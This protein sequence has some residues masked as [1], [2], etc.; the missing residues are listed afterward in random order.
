MP[1]IRLFY[2]TEPAARR[3]AAQ[4]PLLGSANLS[5]LYFPG[6]GVAFSL[7]FHFALF[8][9][10]VFR[11][12]PHPDSLLFKPHPPERF[13]VVFIE[14]KSLMY[15]PMLGGGS[16][17]GQEGG[18]RGG[19][20][21]SGGSEG[22][23]KG[24]KAAPA[25]R[26]PGLVYPGPQPIISDPPN[27][28]NT[29]QTLLQPGIENPP[30]LKP[31][32]ALPNFVQLADAGPAPKPEPPAPPVAEPDPPAPPEP[33][34][35]QAAVAQQEIPPPPPVP[36]LEPVVPTVEVPKMVLPSVA[37]DILRPEAKEPEPVAPPRRPRKPAEP[38]KVVPTHNTIGKTKEIP[39]LET[40]PL[41]T[42]G[43]DP[44]N[45]LALSPMPATRDQ[46]VQIPSGEA[47]ARFA[48]SPDPS[49]GDPNGEPGDVNPTKA[50][51]PV[52][53]AA[54]GLDGSSAT[55]RGNG[56]GG[57][58]ADSRGVGPGAGTGTGPGNST[59]PGSGPGGGTGTGRGTGSGAGV[60]PGSGTGLGTGKG[61]GLGPGTGSGAGSVAGTGSGTATGSGAGTGAGGGTGAGSGPGR[62]PFSGITVVGGVGP[63][64]S[65]A[66][67]SG[68][69]IRPAPRPLQAG[70][71]G[72]TVVSTE[73]S[74]GGL[75]FSGVF[76]HEQIYTVYLDM[77]RNEVEQAPSWTL[78]FAVIEGTGVPAAASD[79]SGGGVQGLVLPFPMTKEQPPLPAEVVRKFPRKMVIVY[80]IINVEGKIEQLTIK[81]SPD[82]SLNEPVLNCL[83]KWVFKPARLNGSTVAVK[84]L[85]GIPL[86]L[87]E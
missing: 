2:R 84:I 49:P 37:E 80:G 71:Y 51:A 16:G 46:P 26:K 68:T 86:A 5:N 38:E 65:A 21:P 39:S 57:T 48:I 73:S 34:A 29:V 24:P 19:G 42:R 69:R 76:S 70:N 18:G 28:T 61:P 14:P 53:A 4:A 36:P 56:G 74:G 22:G 43:T 9:V 7:L 3:R 47:R 55:E 87:P 41:P 15:L 35:P 1:T 60:G 32:M 27:P 54:N 72:I 85:M 12:I 40:A 78:E 31:S 79:T 44:R 6:K 66:N 11:P 75:P 52:T 25:P 67:T 77:R 63:T 62:S 83:A 17:G 8:L 64:G 45:V 13:S 30:V 10:L 23:K 50:T 58:G 33:A 20:L 59:G 82:P 81:D